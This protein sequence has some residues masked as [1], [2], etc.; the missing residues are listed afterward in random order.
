MT[1]RTWEERTCPTSLAICD[2]MSVGNTDDHTDDHT[3]GYT[4]EHRGRA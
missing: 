4:D 1:L 3:D 2:L